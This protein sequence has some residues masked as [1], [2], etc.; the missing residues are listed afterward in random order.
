MKS[1]LMGM[2]A[3]GTFGSIAQFRA[4][5]PRAACLKLAA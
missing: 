2:M 4:L 1:K 5:P 3:Q